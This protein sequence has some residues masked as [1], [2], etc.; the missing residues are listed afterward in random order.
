MILAEIFRSA[1]G[2]GRTVHYPFPRQNRFNPVLGLGDA[3]ASWQDTLERRLAYVRILLAGPLAEAKALN[4][5]LRAIGAGSDMAQ[6]HQIAKSLGCLNDFIDLE[7]RIGYVSPDDLLNE[8]R[9]RVRRWLGRPEIWRAV[10]TIADALVT[11]SRVSAAEIIRAYLESRSEAQRPLDLDW[12][13][14]PQRR[15]RNRSERGV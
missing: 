8:Q 6:C 13:L 9:R 7:A 10:G 1:P 2:S 4:Q 14:A 5:P 3:K 11:K 12:N 15:R